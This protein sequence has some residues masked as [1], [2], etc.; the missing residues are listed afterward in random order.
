MITVPLAS[1]LVLS[2]WFD[3]AAAGRVA[4]IV[5]VVL[6]PGLF[7]L[8][9][10]LSL[11]MGWS[12]S[13][14][15]RLS[16]PATHSVRRGHDFAFER[17][18]PCFVIVTYEDGTVI[19]GW[20]GERSLASSDPDRGDLYLERIYAEDEGRPRSALIS[21]D[22]MRTIEFINPGGSTDDE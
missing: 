22:G 10:G 15:R 9:L 8:L 13:I 19:R 21:L 1:E 4:L 14:L 5:D 16:L 6:I 20:F 2:R 3:P 17:R 18:R 11:W 7:G 12:R